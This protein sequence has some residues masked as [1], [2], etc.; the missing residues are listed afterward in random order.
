LESCY[1]WKIQEFNRAPKEIQE[2]YPKTVLFP[3]KVRTTMVIDDPSCVTDM[4]I[5]KLTVLSPALNYYP[6]NVGK[7]MM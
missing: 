6:G 4:I 1:Y 2:Q 7:S 5:E 3:E